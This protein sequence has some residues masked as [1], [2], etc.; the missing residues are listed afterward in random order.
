MGVAVTAG[1]R[2]GKGQ[3]SLLVTR[4]LLARPALPR[5]L[6]QGDSFTAGVVVN[7]RIGGTPTVRVS[8]E[9]TGARLGGSAMQSAVLEAGRG[10]EVRFD[11][12]QPGEGRPGGADSSSFRFRVT[13]AGASDAVQQRLAV[14]PAYSSRAYTIAGVLADTAT[15]DF[16]LPEGIDPDRSRLELSLGTSPLGIV[17]AMQYELMVYPYWCTEQ[18]SSSAAPIIALYRAQ[19]ALGTPLMKGDPK[20]EI[21]K[22]V[23]V[24]SS[25]QRPDGGIGYWGSSDW[26]TPWLSALA[27]LTL[28]D[29]RAAG[30]VV[31]DTVLARLGDYLSTSL[32]NPVPIRAPVI[33]WYDQL[34]VRLADQVAAADYLSRLRRPDLAAENEL[35]RLAPQLAWEDKARLA[36]VLSRRGATRAARALLEPVW[37]TV[38]VEGRRAIVPDSAAPTYHYFGSRI[39]PV[40]R[41]LTATLAVDS[42]HVLIGP[43]VETLVQQQRA[44]GLDW[45][46]TQDYAATVSALA[47]FSLRQKAASGRGFRVTRAG[48][49]LF[50]ATAGSRL[51]GDSSIVLTG[52]LED[53]TAQHR[54]LRLALAATAPG[55]PIYYYL[56]VREVP[57]QRPLNPDEAGIQVERW[58]ERFDDPKPIIDAREG[59]I[60][61]VRLRVTVPADRQFVVLD[62]ALP[63]G[64]EAIDLSLRTA[65]GIPGPGA[66]RAA[67][68]YFVNANAGEADEGDSG[69][70]GDDDRWYYG[71]WDS[72][73]WSPFDHK[74][75]RDDR[76]LYFATVLWKGTYTAT[77]LARATTPGTFVRPPAQAEEM[78]NPAVR[79]RSDGGIF[80]VTRKPAPDAR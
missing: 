17:R 51:P 4:P 38:R 28:L 14:Q 80:T 33:G 59:E 45:W 57:L 21:E 15:A 60:V 44:T 12:R 8:A 18:V 63:A 49:I 6:R 30:V 74:E 16:S 37:S 1:D 25:R 64:L 29:A 39:R 2:Y 79:G 48:R 66:G 55:T 24:M 22:A 42:S 71:S 47:A 3:S 20:R 58:Y 65:G 19:L 50:A 77:Y 10:R 67:N 34:R 32:H 52:L 40:G 62:D 31:S 68:D 13:G 53:A 23:A 72:G 27:G 43:L 56:T 46:N 36:E 11:F 61:R 41:L 5:F 76:V 69:D 26:T 75:M 54:R 9:A 70:G 7:Q 78:Y 35:L 73:W